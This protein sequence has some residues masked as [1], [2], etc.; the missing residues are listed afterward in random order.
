MTTGGF[1]VEE[2]VFLLEEPKE[3]LDVVEEDEEEEE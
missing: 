1:M 2:D 3:D